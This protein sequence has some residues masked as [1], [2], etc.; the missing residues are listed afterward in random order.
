MIIWMPRGDRK[1]VSSHCIE[2]PQEGGEDYKTFWEAFGRNI[3]IGVIEDQ[4][5][6]EKLS[7]LLRFFSSHSTEQA[8]GNMTSFE[9]YVAR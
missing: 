9:Q 8:D 5:N 4:D 6:R 7:K 3:K 2:T 1:L